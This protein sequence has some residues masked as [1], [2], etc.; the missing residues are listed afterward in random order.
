MISLHR[1]SYP[2]TNSVDL[3]TLKLR[4]PPASAS[5][6][7]GLK[8]CTTSQLRINALK[9]VIGAGKTA[10]WIQ[11]LPT[12]LGDLSLISRTQTVREPSPTSPL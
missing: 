2:K 4:D 12:K 3:P 6:V 7:L 1:P 5:P 8:E 10:H 11:G 9:T